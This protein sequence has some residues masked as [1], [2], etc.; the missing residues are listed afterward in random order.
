MIAAVKASF[1]QA[2]RLGHSLDEYTFEQHWND[3][4]ER[5]L[6][7]GTWKAERALW[8]KRYFNRYFKEYF[9]HADS[10][11]MLLNDITPL[12][13]H[14]YWDLRKAYWLT[15]KYPSLSCPFWH[16]NSISFDKDIRG[17]DELSHDCCDGDFCGFSGVSQRYASA[18]DE[19]FSL[20]LARLTCMRHDA[21]KAAHLSSVQSFNFEQEGQNCGCRDLTQAREWSAGYRASGVDFMGLLPSPSTF[22]ANCM[23]IYLGRWT[24]R[25]S[26][27]LSDQRAWPSGGFEQARAISFASFSPSKILDCGGVEL[28]LRARAASSPLSTSWRWV[29]STVERLVSNASA[30]RA[31]SQPQPSAQTSAFSSIRALRSR[32][33]ASRPERIMLAICAR[34]SA[35]SRRTYFTAGLHLPISTTSESFPE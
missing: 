10:T 11:S 23:A 13:A 34:S 12:H 24:A 1:W 33:A 19:G 2:A 8:H 21:G 32:Y 4:Y 27:S 15:D 25:F 6:C 18:A 9:S 16:P 7:N 26:K 30:I 17:F 20:P 35:F 29:R 31:S 14:G 5:N 22:L 3:W 28:F